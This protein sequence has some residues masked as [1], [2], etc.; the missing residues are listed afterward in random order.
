MSAW[1][2]LAIPA[3]ILAER[4]RQIDIEYDAE[5]DDEHDGGELLRAAT[6]Y[7]RHATAPET[8]EVTDIL[9]E[10]RPDPHSP[11][12]LVPVIRSIPITWPWEPKWWK[13][14]TPQRDLDRAGA[15]CLAEIDRLKRAGRPED[16]ARASEQLFEIMLALRE[17]PA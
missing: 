1:D 15:L 9:I 17:L 12:R 5:H 16:C 6:V 7:Y 2:D 11:R 13:P 3:S 10:N 8:L 14:K 4:Q